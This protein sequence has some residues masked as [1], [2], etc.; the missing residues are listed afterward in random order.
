MRH[1]SSLCVLPLVASCVCAEQ[2][3]VA[4]PEVSPPFD[5]TV[6]VAANEV[7]YTLPRHVW[8]MK[9]VGYRHESV[10]DTTTKSA[11]GKTYSELILDLKMDWLKAAYYAR[12]G[13]P[14]EP[15]VIVQNWK[16]LADR[17]VDSG[18]VYFPEI[19]I[20]PKGF[21]AG[22]SKLPPEDVDN[23]DDVVGGGSVS[24]V[25]A[26]FDLFA[27][28]KG[29]DKLRGYEPYN[30]PCT[31][32]DMQ[33][34]LKHLWYSKKDVA[35]ADR[36][37]ADWATVHQRLIAAPL[38]EKYPGLTVCGSAFSSPASSYGIGEL[39]RFIK[40][41]EGWPWK[42]NNAK[43]MTA[44]S[45][46]SYGFRAGSGGSLPSAPDGGQSSINSYFY[47]T[48]S[49]PGRQSGYKAAI[50]KILEVLEE[51]GGEKVK[52]ANTEWWALGSKFLDAEAGSRS[53]L[54]DVIGA[55]VHCQN[56][57]KWRFDSLT[58]HAANPA[59]IASDLSKW[60]GPEDCMVGIA[61]QRLYRPVRYYVAKDIVG[62][63]LNNYKKLV[64]VQSAS[65]M[66][67]QGTAN[68]PIDSI[69][70][71]AG[72]SDTEDKI[73]VLIIN[74]NTRQ[75]VKIRVD[76]GGGVSGSARATL[77]PAAQPIDTPLPVETIPVKD[78]QVSLTIDPAGAVLLE[79]SRSFS[80]G[81]VTGP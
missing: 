75:A 3:S 5:A 65:P 76:L 42:D 14:S 78:N 74:A 81:R 54:G 40:G 15:D 16:T 35:Q 47:P 49:N 18:G 57:D 39:T 68:N 43:Q 32:T 7:Y 34:P 19:H 10:N 48:Y 26:W 21:L 72:T 38:M 23:I 56:A 17:I 31:R 79:A 77:L 60:I 53:A 52:I 69:Q 64:R 33:S 73:A 80:Q 22:G 58:L 29:V 2:A 51:N 9:F 20:L 63:F 55:V 46:H 36:K 25:L 11:D 28:E 27:K 6:E 59:P 62:K 71:C 37:A 24:N 45:V 66:G 70:A 30:E 12:F 44:L 50:D 1:F 41:Y 8:G 4:E 13:T 61:N 67:P